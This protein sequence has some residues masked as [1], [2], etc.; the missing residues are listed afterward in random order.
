MKWIHFEGSV[1]SRPVMK[2][3]VLIKRL[4]QNQNFGDVEESRPGLWINS[5]IWGTESICTRVPTG[6]RQTKAAEEIV[7]RASSKLSLCAPSTNR[8][9]DSPSC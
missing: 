7:L 3:G 5:H 4:E 1:V 8:Q 2:V 9:F 6:V